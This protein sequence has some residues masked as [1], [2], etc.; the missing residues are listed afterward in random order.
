LRLTGLDLRN[1][2]RTDLR[3][4]DARAEAAVP[5]SIEAAKHATGAVSARD[6][7]S[8][9]RVRNSDHRLPLS[10]AKLPLAIAGCRLAAVAS[11]RQLHQLARVT[12]RTAT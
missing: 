3:F 9:V 8:A 10:T 7:A 6:R 11:R 1:S 4:H 12:G 5:D 2:T